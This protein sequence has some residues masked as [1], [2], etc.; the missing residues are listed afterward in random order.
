MLYSYAKVGYHC[1]M[2][3]AFSDQLED[4]LKSKQPKTLGQLSQVFGEKSFA[5]TIL[6]LMFIPALPLPTGGITHVFEVI[7]MLL[8][9]EMIIGRRIIW[10]PKRWQNMQLGT[11]T[12]NKAV[13]FISRRIKWFEKLSRPR[14]GHMLDHTVFLRLVGLIILIFTLAAFLAPP[15]SGLDTL[16]ALGVVAIALSLILSDFMV[17]VIGVLIGIAGIGLIIGLGAA[18]TAGV[19]RLI[20]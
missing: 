15:F 12:L 17:S 11:V 10:L 3:I 1:R 16:P 9:L 20:P 14:L 19:E 4:W 6:L 13:P 2:A 18:I 5:I 7:T 8:S